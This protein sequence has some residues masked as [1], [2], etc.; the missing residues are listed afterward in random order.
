MV[1]HRALDN[2]HDSPTFQPDAGS[3]KWQFFISQSVA[4]LICLVGLWLVRL[5]QIKIVA[6]SMLCLVYLGTIYSHGFLF[7]TIH[8]PSIVGYFILV[9]LAGLFF[10]KRV[11]L[12]AVALSAATIIITFGL[13]SSGLITPFMP[14]TGTVDDLLFI[15]VGFGLNTSLMLA[16]LTDIEES[17]GDA[18]KVASAL[19]VTNR[20]L[21]ANQ[22]LAPSS[23]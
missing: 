21:Q 22:V 11:M 15:L 1:V 16:I 14:V 12:V 10:G 8:D 20:E 13:E 3:L 5:G 19:T 4:I 23:A 2:R 6:I 18:Y 9:P 17:A 7:R